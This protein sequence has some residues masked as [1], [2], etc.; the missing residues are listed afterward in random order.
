MFEL[1]ILPNAIKK[2]S[3]FFFVVCHMEIW[4]LPVC[5]L[6]VQKNSREKIKL[7]LL[8]II[9]SYPTALT[10]NGKWTQHK[11]GHICV[12]SHG[13][14]SDETSLGVFDQMYYVLYVLSSCETDTILLI[15]L[16]TNSVTQIMY[17]E[18]RYPVF[19]YKEVWPVGRKQIKD[20]ETP[21]MG[22]E[23]ETR[24]NENGVSACSCV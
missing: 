2:V 23:K 4:L 5:S 11:N 14:E 24:L 18:S 10:T 20:G 1:A 7:Y 17:S 8:W 22:L 13:W 6:S 3:I 15:L 16:W 19:L 12:S 21:K 9:L